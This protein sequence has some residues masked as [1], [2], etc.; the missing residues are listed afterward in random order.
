MT[1]PLRTISGFAE[2][3]VA[4]DPTTEQRDRVRAAHPR[5]EPAAG[6]DAARPARL[7]ARRPRDRGERDGRRGHGGAA[8]CATTSRPGSPSATPRSVPRCPPT[9]RVPIDPNDLRIIL[10]N[11]VSNAIKFADPRRARGH[12]RR[13]AQRRRVARQ[14]RRQRPRDPAGA[15][16]QRIFAAFE[17]APSSGIVGYGLGLA[18]CQRLVERHGGRIGLAVQPAGRNAL[19]VHLAGSGSDRGGSPRAPR[20]ACSS[21][22]TTS[23]TGRLRGWCSRWPATRSSARPATGSRRSSTLPVSPRTSCCWTS[24]CRTW[25]ASRRSRTCASGCPGSKI[26][27]LTTGQALQERQR[28]LDS[29]ADGY[30]VKPDRVFALDDEI[31][32]ALAA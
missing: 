24:T 25:A 14:R 13:R 21:V 27:I 29:G 5:L 18:I 7:R 11:L 28:A 8:R 19:L 10:Q 2:F 32:A 23:S 1:D 9:R 22:T 16:R 4:T 6:G 15:T 20:C 26:L 3:L 31:K 30:I 12:G 17:R